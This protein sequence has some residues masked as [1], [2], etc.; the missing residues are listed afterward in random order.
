MAALGL[1]AIA[2]FVREKTE[3]TRSEGLDFFDTGVAL[4]TDKPVANLA[5]ITSDEASEVCW[6]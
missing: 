5:S 3:P 6:G 2:T 4:V 1:Q